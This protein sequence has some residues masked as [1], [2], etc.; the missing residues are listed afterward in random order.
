MDRK[1]RG[2]AFCLV[3]VLFAIS[4]PVVKAQ[5]ATTAM[6][7]QSDLDQML[8]PIALYPDDLL[9]NVLTAATYPLEVVQADRFVKQNPALQTDALAAALNSQP[10]DQSVK[11]L[12]QFPS[13]LAMM[14]DQLSWTEQVGDAYLA[15]PSAVM[16]TVQELRAK[17]QENGTLESNTQQTVVSDGNNVIIQPYVA[18]IVY[19]PYYDPGIVYGAWWWPNQPPL[20]WN[21]PPRYRPNSYGNIGS[22]GIAYGGRVVVSPANFPHYRPNW[23]S[24]TISV[25]GNPGKG[26]SQGVW[27]HDPAHRLGVAYRTTPSV[28]RTASPAATPTVIAPQRFAPDRQVQQAQ[29]TQQAQQ[30]RPGSMPEFIAHQPAMPQPQRLDM[31]RNAAPQPTPQP[32]PQHAAA[33]AAAPHGEAKQNNDPRKPAN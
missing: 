24:H 33:P 17:A 9:S 31:P 15:Q 18:D 20:F 8:A 30:A 27:Q 23:G 11:A 5:D 22:G 6:F 28:N 14:D 26:N 13:V 3:A 32:E 1:L 25:T 29:Q 19:V 21:P 12:T 4:Q 2:F 10:W 7:G 16:D